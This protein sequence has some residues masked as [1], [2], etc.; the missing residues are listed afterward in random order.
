MSCSPTSL[1]THLGIKSLAWAGSGGWR[2]FRDVTPQSWRL[3]SPSHAA[4]VKLLSRERRSLGAARD[5]RA[6]GGAPTGC[7]A[8]HSL[9]PSASER[10]VIGVHFLNF[11]LTVTHIRPNP[12]IMPI[13]S[14][15][16]PQL[17]FFVEHSG[18]EL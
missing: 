5:E 14:G 17:S 4:A 8:I 1:T 3:G 15:V 7:V 2:E 18:P 13:G 16:Y 10:N 9:G 6:E 12:L 11:R